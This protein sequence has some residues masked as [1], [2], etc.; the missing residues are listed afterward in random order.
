VRPTAPTR[1]A[2]KTAPADL[3]KRG[4]ELQERV[5]RRAWRPG[6]AVVELLAGGDLGTLS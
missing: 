4:A 5:H 1:S 6:G 2:P 3:K